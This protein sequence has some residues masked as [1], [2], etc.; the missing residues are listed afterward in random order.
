[1]RTGSVLGTVGALS[2]ISV[3]LLGSCVE[4]D[5]TPLF[6]AVSR[7][8]AAAAERLLSSG[9][10]VD[11]VSPPYSFTPL[12]ESAGRSTEITRL[13]L[14]AGADPNLVDGRGWPPLASAAYRGSI[15]DAELLLQYGAEPDDPVQDGKH[16]GERPCDL[17]PAEA[18]EL[19]QLLC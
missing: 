19:R 10:N 2:L 6:D 12:T 15:N 18:E 11:Q 17:A 8:D 14:K 4:P 16:S 1:M 5:P 13:L 3:L 9:S 7:G